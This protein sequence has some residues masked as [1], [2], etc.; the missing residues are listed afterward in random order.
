[1][2]LTNN[3]KSTA[4]AEGYDGKD[5]LIGLLLLI[6]LETFLACHRGRKLCPL[7]RALSL[8]TQGLPLHSHTAISID[9]GS[10]CLS[11][12]GRRPSCTIEAA[13]PLEMTMIIRKGR[14]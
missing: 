2:P 1:M 8:H 12:C 10:S 6:I 9:I 11:I 7:S 4:A 3:S 14:L 5:V 13:H